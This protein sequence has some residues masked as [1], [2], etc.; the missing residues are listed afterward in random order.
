MTFQQEKEK[1]KERAREEKL[2]KQTVKQQKRNAE[3]EYDWL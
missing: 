3:I 2:K 1:E